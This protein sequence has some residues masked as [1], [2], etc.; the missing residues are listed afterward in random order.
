MLFPIRLGNPS[1]SK[2]GGLEDRQGSIF[3]CVIRVDG[4]EQPNTHGGRLESA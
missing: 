1:F 4:S 3:M 2:H